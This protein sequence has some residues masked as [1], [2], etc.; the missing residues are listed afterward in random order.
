MSDNFNVANPTKEN[1][2][3]AIKQLLFFVTASAS[4]EEY[5]DYRELC[6]NALAK[7]NKILPIYF[8]TGSLKNMDKDELQDIMYDLLD[9]EVGTQGTNAY[10]YGEGALMWIEVIIRLRQY[11]INLGGVINDK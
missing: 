10:Y 5:K 6:N 11:E 1:I 8:N 3:H 7:I 9:L 2:E 4:I